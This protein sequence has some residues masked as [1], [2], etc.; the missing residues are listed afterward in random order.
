MQHGQIV[1]RR[2]SRETDGETAERAALARVRRELRGPGMLS[3][4]VAI[5]GYC[6]GKIRLPLVALS[7]SG[8]LHEIRKGAVSAAARTGAN[9]DE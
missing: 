1:P 6:A 5:C 8:L 4:V 3:R 7:P 2:V 9:C